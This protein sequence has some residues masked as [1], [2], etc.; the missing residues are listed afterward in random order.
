MYQPERLRSLRLAESGG[1]TVHPELMNAFRERFNISI[2]PVWGSTEATGIALASP[3]EGNCPR[4]SMGVPCKY[5]EVKI[6]DDEGREVDGNEVGEMIIKGPAVCSAYY[7]EP[8]ETA[9]HMRDGWLYTGDLVK[10]DAEGFFYFISRREGMMKV[11]GLRVYPAEIERFLLAHDAVQEVAVVRVNDD[12][13]GEAPKAVVVLK[14]GA[15]ISDMELKRFCSR[16]MPKYKVPTI[17]EFRDELPKTPGG[18]VLYAK[19]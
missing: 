16:K 18:K 7:E 11:A 14:K 17:I 4:G 6:V 10:K 15:Q 13:L 2:T 1:A 12:T 9:K 8:D 3:M 5:Y 19:L